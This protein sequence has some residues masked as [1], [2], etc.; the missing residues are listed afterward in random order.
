MSWDEAT[1]RA[2]LAHRDD[3]LAMLRRLVDDYA[4]DLSD[5]ERDAFDDML[6]QLTS[7]AFGV[8]TAKQR[9]WAKTVAERVGAVGYDNLVSS[10]RVPRGREVPTPAVLQRLP[11]KPPGRR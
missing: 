3:D 8:L 7:G 4:T 11:L 2:G 6:E 10:G 1:R 5:L 9:D